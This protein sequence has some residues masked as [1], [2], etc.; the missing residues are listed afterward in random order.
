MT[1]VFSSDELDAY[2]SSYAGMEGGNIGAAV[3]ICDKEPHLLATAPGA[4]LTPLHEPPAWDSAFRE[5]H[6]H[7]MQRWQTHQRLARIMAATRAAVL[8]EPV[9]ELDW[10]SYFDRH[11]YGP[12][13][14]EFK[15]NL[16]PLP[17]PQQMDLSQ[18]ESFRRNP[19]LSPNWRYVE[20]CRQG[21]RFRFIAGLR[22]RVHPKVILCT[23]QAEEDEFLMAFGF[24]GVPCSEHHLQ[25]ADLVKTLRVYSH[26][27][28]H[29]VICPKV[30]GPT[31]IN[32]DTLL[33][34]M[35]A[36]LSVWL[37]AADFPDA[38]AM[39]GEFAGGGTGL[40]WRPMAPALTA[41][42]AGAPS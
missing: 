13:G 11:L 12:R 4:P 18:I 25:P 27:G 35:G 9:P 42:T 3:W 16:Y 19:Y 5:R 1:S 8:R 39:R 30:G 22:R 7:D 33:D 15:L 31:G 23:G 36:Y 38:H 24:E 21:G 20:F 6:R 37:D 17:K 40:A 28:T 14:W 10:R 34:A 29:L 32:S 41:S 26:E 2:F